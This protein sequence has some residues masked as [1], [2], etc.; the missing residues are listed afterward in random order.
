MSTPS[1]ISFE[2]F[3][4]RTPEAAAKLPAV[5]EQ[6][7]AAAPAY[8]SVTHGAGGSDQD[9][10]YQT[11]TTVV[12]QTGIEVA[13]HLT[14]VGSTRARVGELLERYRACGVKR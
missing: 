2:L 1:K 14:C 12:A 10:T 11:L 5:L 4:P 7:A 9:G 6:L 3:P 13:P 8:F